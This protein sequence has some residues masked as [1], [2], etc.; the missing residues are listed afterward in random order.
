MARKALLMA[1]IA[2]TVLLLSGC[3]PPARSG[4]EGGCS[5]GGSCAPTED[6]ASDRESGGVP[7]GGGTTRGEPAMIPIDGGEYEIGADDGI[8][9]DPDD[10]RPPHTVLLRWF[11]IDRHEVTN[12]RFA[13]FLN[14]LGVEPL[15]D[16]AA[17][18]VDEKDLEKSDEPRLLE[19]TE[20]DERRPLVA[21]DDEHSRIGISDG[22]FAVREEAENL[23]VAETTWYGARDYCAWRGA[24]LPTEAEWEA[25]A[26]GRERRTYPWGEA[27]VTRERAVFGTG[28]PAP[29]GSRPAGA[30]PGGVMDMAGNLAEW[31]ST[32]YKPYPYDANDGREDPDV[33]GERVTRG[34]DAYFSDAEELKP[35]ARTGF[36]RE[37][38]RG[39]RHIGFRCARSIE[40][41]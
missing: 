18:E 31:T 38:D 9:P 28:E 34:G 33:A 8:P 1:A 23:P 14:S 39:H 4:G 16:A 5:A 41:S 7:S 15:R 3:E 22:R 10:E 6:E 27:P 11:A 35:A 20:G 32:L 21:L 19:G 24:R 25:A 12:A 37:F 2:G 30:T 29:V 26:R 13:Q 17:G 40:Y 36:S